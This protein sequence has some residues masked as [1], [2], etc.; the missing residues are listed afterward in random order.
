[1]SD[2]QEM[3]NARNARPELRLSKG[4]FEN[5]GAATTPVDRAFGPDDA[6]TAWGVNGWLGLPIVAGR[7]RLPAVCGGR[8]CGTILA[9]H[10]ESI[11]TA[12]NSTNRRVIIPGALRRFVGV[13]QKPVRIS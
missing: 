2:G 12:T 4:G 3:R 5:E 1:M 10:A 9:P 6:I 13:R 11:R 8:P 7:G